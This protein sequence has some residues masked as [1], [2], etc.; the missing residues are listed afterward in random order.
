[1]SHSQGSDRVRRRAVRLSSCRGILIAALLLLA[2]GSNLIYFDRLSAL[3]ALWVDEMEGVADI[4][5][6]LI[7]APHS[8]D[9][10]I[11]SAG[12][13]QRVLAQG[14]EVRVVLVTNGDGSFSGTIVELRK[15]YLT[16]R[17]YILAGRS[18]QQ[19]SLRAMQALGVP[20][21]HLVFLSYPDR[22]TSLLWRDHW[23]NANPYRSPILAPRKALTS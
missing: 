5:R 16:S 18:R 22:G 6:L 1:M 15:I 9:E 2:L 19:E 4:R 17:E 21:E 12:L 13:I 14:G 3:P 10:T 7:I 11:S 8:D 20:A 23:S